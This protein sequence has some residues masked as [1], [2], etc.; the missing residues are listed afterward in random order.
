MADGNQKEFFQM[1]VNWVIPPGNYHDYNAVPGSIWIR[2]LQFLKSFSEKGIES[3][4]NKNEE[5][6]DAVI[7]LRQQTR[8]HISLLR[9]YKSQGVPTLFIVGVNY[10]ER[11]G[12]IKKLDQSVS[13]QQMYECIAMTTEAD[14][15]ITASSYLEDCARRYNPNVFYIPDTI[16]GSH[17]CHTKIHKDFQKRNLSLVWCGVSVKAW[18]LDH[19]V[20][21]M[22]GLPVD[23]IVISE[24]DPALHIAH[25]FIKWD[26]QAFP[27]DIL[28]GDICVSPRILDN[29]YDMG[30]SSF[31]IIPFMSA[32][33]PVLVSRQPSYTEIITKGYNGYY[34]DIEGTKKWREYLE[35]MLKDRDRLIE[36][37]DNAQKSVMRFHN[38]E[39]MFE[40]DRLFRKINEA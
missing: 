5:K 40:Y 17:F 12:N 37:S 21:V 35:A 11:K 3:V 32:G 20:G 15:I 13:P 38:K 36:M 9:K 6:V 7:F 31:K 1:K 30:H 2:C 16:D 10:Y 28:K 14:Y 19:L 4:I 34:A 26:Y 23:L 24:K 29:S 39:I 25:Q 27:K 8:D 22:K 33:L 18:V